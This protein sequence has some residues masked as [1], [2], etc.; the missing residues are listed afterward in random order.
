MGGVALIPS[1][2]CMSSPQLKGGGVCGFNSLCQH[3]QG[4]SICK[5]PSGY[6]LMDPYDVLK[7]C[8]QNFAHKAVMRPQQRPIFSIFK[9]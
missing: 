5:C 9:R 2:L 4:Q 3:D 6:T 7:G 1:N 8:K